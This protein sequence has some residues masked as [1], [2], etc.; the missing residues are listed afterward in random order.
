M[1]SLLPASLRPSRPA[2]PD[3]S[4]PPDGS[5]AA[6][7]LLAGLWAAGLGLLVVAFV[8]ILAWVAAPHPSSRAGGAVRSAGQL[9]LMAHHVPLDVP[10]GSIGLAPLGLTVLPAWLLV[11]AGRRV[12]RALAGAGRAGGARDRLVAL[13]ALTGGYG[14][15]A[16]VLAWAAR[17]SYARPSVPLAALA[18]TLLAALCGGYGAWGADWPGKRLVDRLGVGARAV[19]AA[20]SAALCLLLAAGS[21]LAAAALAVHGAQAAE[22]T[23]TVAPGL[24]D[25]LLLTLLGA[26]LVPNGVVWAAAVLVGPGFAVGEATAV[27]PVA[28]QLG[29]IPAFPLLA[30]LPDPGPLPVA[31]L[32]LLA[33]PAA[34]G[35]TLAVVLL[36]RRAGAGAAPLRP[37]EAAGHA[38]VAGLLAGALLGLLAGLSG[39]PVGGGRLSAVGPSPWQVALAA[40][41][42]LAVAGGLTAYGVAR[43][44]G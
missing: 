6:R 1:V 14:T 17:S 8:V 15:A 10:G 33:A 20:A 32:G 38:A 16:T 9:W 22:L 2:G 27:T 28:V 40:A 11:A 25:G 18:A 26:L 39:G 31:A 34:A 12:G 36:R 37:L 29:P 30:A 41:V 23:R 42:E 5:A 7:G 43:R 13:A 21:V 35:S 44:G 4:V 3:E 24:V 19:L